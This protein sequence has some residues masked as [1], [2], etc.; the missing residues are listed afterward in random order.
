MKPKLI[1]I[2]SLHFGLFFLL[3]LLLAGCSST[4]DLWV[5]TDGNWKME[6]ELE[7]NFEAIPGI[8]T[9]IEGFGLDFDL[10]SITGEVYQF[11]LEQKVMLD[12][13]RGLDADLDVDK[14]GDATVYQYTLEGKNINQL[15][16]S[17]MIDEALY[18]QYPELEDYVGEFLVLQHS[19]GTIE[20]EA[21]YP[22]MNLGHTFILHGKNIDDYG[23]A[24][25]IKGNKAYW[26]NPT[27]IHARFLPINKSNKVFIFIIWG[28]VLLGVAVFFFLQ[29]EGINLRK[30]KPSYGRQKKYNNPY[31]KK[32][33]YPDSKHKNRK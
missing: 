7:F 28:V 31:Y 25:E 17:L 16:E 5:Y 3:S 27:Y 33:T 1:S 6:M 24:T 14:Y 9:S 19:D 29:F 26:S 8:S 4:Q 23:T 10:G 22:Y 15:K 21:T 20:I 12:R 2:N 13:A 11:I 30:P 32:R 18:E